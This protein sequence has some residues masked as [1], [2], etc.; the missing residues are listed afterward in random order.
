M[1]AEQCRAR[2]VVE[3][4]AANIDAGAEEMLVRQ[5]IEIVPDLLAGAAGDI[6]SALEWREARLEP[7]FR[8]EDL[9]TQVRRQMTLAARRVRVARAR[10]E[11]DLRTAAICTALERIAKVYEIRGVFP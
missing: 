1:R 5:G 2:V 7:S 8:K 6:S 3:V 9:D 4:G 10:Y 11:C